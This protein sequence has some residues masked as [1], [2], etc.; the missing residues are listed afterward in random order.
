MSDNQEQGCMT[1]C[2]YCTKVRP[3]IG[4]NCPL[5]KGQRAYHQPAQMMA[6]ELAR[7]HVL[8]KLLTAGTSLDTLKSAS[9]TEQL[10]AAQQLRDRLISTLQSMTIY[11]F[12]LET[13]MIELIHTLECDFNLGPFR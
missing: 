2:V 4:A 12:D 11:G 6:G 9:D 7:Q 5:C 10:Q 1:E 3:E 13:S 8:Q